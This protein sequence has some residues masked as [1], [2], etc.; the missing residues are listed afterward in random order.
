[1]S[2]FCLWAFYARLGAVPKHRRAFRLLCDA[3]NAIHERCVTLQGTSNTVTFT[4][5]ILDKRAERYGFEEMKLPFHLLIGF[6]LGIGPLLFLIAHWTG[7]GR[8]RKVRRY[9]VIP[10]RF[11]E[12]CSYRRPA[13]S[14]GRPGPTG[15]D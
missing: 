14:G 12:C 1:M 13:C 6:W 11:L 8:L 3:R 9:K 5:A 10:D 2:L 15:A 4:T 7:S